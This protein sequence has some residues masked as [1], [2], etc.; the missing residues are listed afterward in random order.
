MHA[1]W[2]HLLAEGCLRALPERAGDVRLVLVELVAQQAH[3]LVVAHEGPA[4]PLLGQL[5]RRR[6]HRGRQLGRSRQRR[7]LVRVALELDLRLRQLGAQLLLG[8]DGAA[9]PRLR[10]GKGGGQQRRGQPTRH[11]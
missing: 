8:L 3:R 11:R 1:T 10:G 7:V 2:P 9:M 4:V 5:R 6:P